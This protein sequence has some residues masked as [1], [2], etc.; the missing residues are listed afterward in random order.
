MQVLVELWAFFRPTVECRSSSLQPGMM[1]MLDAW[2]GSLA[3]RESNS[4]FDALRGGDF[5]AE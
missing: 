3:M 5:L 4:L 1:L 2:L